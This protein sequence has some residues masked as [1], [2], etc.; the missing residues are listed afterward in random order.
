MSHYFE[1]AIF[2]RVNSVTEE[3]YERTRVGIFEK[4]PE[5]STVEVRCLSEDGISTYRSTNDT[6]AA[7]D[8]CHLPKKEEANGGSVIHR[9]T[10]NVP[11]ASCGKIRRNTL[12]VISSHICS[13]SGSST[14]RDDS[15]YLHV[16][17]Q[18]KPATWAI[19][20][21]DL[22]VFNRLLQSCG[23][24]HKLKTF[25][26]GFMMTN[27]ETE[28]GP[29]A[30]EYALRS[31]TYRDCYDGFECAYIVRLMEYTNR[32]EKDPWSLRKFALYHKYRS[33]P[34]DWC[35]T[36]ILIGASQRTEACLEDYRRGVND[37]KSANPF[38][39][40]IIFLDV[41]IAAWRPY[42]ADLLIEI[43]DLT[44]NAVAVIIEHEDHPNNFVTIELEDHQKLTQIGDTIADVLLCLDS[45][46]DTI[47]T[48]CKIYVTL[49]RFKKHTGAPKLES[50]VIDVAFDKLKAHV[51]YTRK[52]AEALQSKA[53]NTREL[54]SLLSEKQN[55]Y[56]LN[57][58]MTAL[59]NIEKDASEENA[60]VRQLAEKSSQDSSSV[61]ILTII[62]L[63]YLPCTV[64]SSFYSTQFVHQD[65]PE[66]DVFS[67]GYA[68]NAW[69]F[70]AVSIPLTFF[71]IMVWYMWVNFGRML[72]ACKLTDD[73][74]RDVFIR[75]M[76]LPRLRKQRAGGARCPA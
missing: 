39:L 26:V 74:R 57:Q 41:A 44:S 9:S 75:H 47:A 62:M 1:Q 71:T 20:D 50:S 3:H 28:M 63:I 43:A 68:Q 48:L 34:Q 55:G 7:P 76:Q 8:S 45:T 70:F 42:L 22:N 31:S 35:S 54:I 16:V 4:D 2:H 51:E 18:T 10:V 64:V 19:F 32:P 17:P 59:Q 27:N 11:C 46:L 38:E 15:Q 65:Q 56:N 29:P 69:L 14:L 52:K 37:F 33:D 67:M 58:Q 66:T 23:V 40:H 60:M 53:R 61:K 21:V 72:Q 36:W 49:P 6:N 30:I 25:T 73:N 24:F 5:L 13:A 12:S